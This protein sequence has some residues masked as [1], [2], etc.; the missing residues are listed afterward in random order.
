MIWTTLKLTLL[1]LGCLAC[2]ILFLA[3]ADGFIDVLSDPNSCEGKAKTFK[4]LV[5]C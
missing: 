5:R 1:C 4:E 2:L 3:F